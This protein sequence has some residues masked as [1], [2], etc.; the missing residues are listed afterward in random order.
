[1]KGERGFTLVEMLVATA[2]TGLVFSVLGAAV[3]QVVTV[4]EYG[5]DRVTALHELQNAAYWVNL[6]GQMAKSATGGATLVLTLTDNSTISYTLAGTDLIRSAGT[7]NRTLAQNIAGVSFS[8]QGRYIT[9]DISASPASRWDVS[10]N[11]TY[12]VYLRP[13]GS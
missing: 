5:N 10:E 7:S 2:I 4:P 8:V 11:K 3:H 1:M 12:Q 13:T 6:D 9:M